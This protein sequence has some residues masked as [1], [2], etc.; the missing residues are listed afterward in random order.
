MAYKRRKRSHKRHYKPIS[1]HMVRAIKAISQQPVETKR[2]VASQALSAWLSAA[3]YV[4]PSTGA[5]IRQN[6]LGSLPRI[7]NTP[8]DSESGFSGDKVNLRGFKWEIHVYPSTSA[9]N[10]NTMM[11]FTVYQSPDY[12]ANTTGPGPTDKIWDE[13][14]DRSPTWAVWNVQTTKILF[15][16]NFV[17]NQSSTDPSV[18]NKKFYIPIR[19]TITSMGDESSVANSYMGEVMGLQMYWT[20]EILGINVPNLATGIVGVINTSLYFK[21]P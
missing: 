1:K 14:Y 4:A 5:T 3:G 2:F 15:Q 7:T 6:F 13:D 8:P 20:L 16:R 10:P 19:R 11:R 9:N 17:I 18:C 21:D 12:F